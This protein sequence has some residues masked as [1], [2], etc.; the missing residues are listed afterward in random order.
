MNV[1]IKCGSVLDLLQ[2]A[3]STITGTWKYK[4]AAEASYQATVTGTGSISATVIIDV[5]ND[6]INAIN[7]PLGTIVLSGTT[8]DSD[9][10]TSNAPWKF[11]R[12]RISAISGTGA[13]VSVNTGV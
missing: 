12:A 9:G 4:D 3:T 1:H 2:G 13:T 8:T 5:S 7:T 10:F 11:V 6:G